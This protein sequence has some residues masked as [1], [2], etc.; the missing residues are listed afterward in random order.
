MS[1]EAKF[2]AKRAKYLKAVEKRTAIQVELA[3]KYGDGFKNSWLNAGELRRLEGA[4]TRA[5]DLADE[6]FVFV[7][8]IS[9]RDWSNGIPFT[10]IVEKLTY[11]DAVTRGALSVVPPAS[12]GGSASDNERF[13]RPLP[14]GK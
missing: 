13:A 12:Y 4:K 10:W 3:T 8:S 2:D 14:E 7:A 1:N 9:P 6:F 11:A 5:S